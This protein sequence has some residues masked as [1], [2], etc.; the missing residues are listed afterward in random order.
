M[1]LHI[2]NKKRNVVKVD[3]MR[4][5][6]HGIAIDWKV[7]N[8]LVSLISAP[9]ETVKKIFHFEPTVSKFQIFKL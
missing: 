1:N 7:F 9:V 6:L 4:K 8:Y 5:L 3:F 2:S